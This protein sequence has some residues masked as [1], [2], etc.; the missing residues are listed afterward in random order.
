MTEKEKTQIKAF[1]DAAR[2][3]SGDTSEAEF[4]RALG[5]IGR[6]KAPKD[7]VKPSDRRKRKPI[8]VAAGKSW[9]K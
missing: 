2:A 5:K 9:N 4:D 6:A 7:D 3:I 8:E 1:R